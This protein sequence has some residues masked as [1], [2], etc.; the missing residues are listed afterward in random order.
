LG[1]DLSHY[2]P[3]VLERVIYAGVHSSSFE[4]A[5]A[6]LHH[7]GDLDISTKQVERLTKQIDTER[8]RER[9]VAVRAYR[10]RPLV[11]RKSVPAEVTAPDL[12]VVE[13]DGGRL[14]I[15]DRSASKPTEEPSATSHWQEDKVG[16]LATMTS[17]VSSSDPCPT[18]PEHF[19]DPLRIVKLTREIK[20]SAGVAEDEVRAESTPGEAKPAAAASPYTA[21]A[22]EQR[23]VVATRGDVHE[24]G[25]IL[26]EAAWTR[27]FDGR[28]GEPLWRM[29]CRVIGECGNV[30]S[31]KQGLPIASSHIEST[32]KRIKQR[33]KGTEKFWSE[34]GAEAIL[35]LRADTLSETDPLARFWERRQTAA[36]GERRH[37]N[38]I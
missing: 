27:G 22:L 14:Q 29:A 5:H 31:R 2:S 18:I 23:S 24:F 26:A 16:L 36:T 25:G 34:A 20:G 28:R 9:D 4:L 12:A 7:L 35:Q 1:I 21:P 32:I 11:E 8:C 19:V 6:A 33:V 37:S 13:M 15:L 3:A 30:I 17:E 38:A 10:E